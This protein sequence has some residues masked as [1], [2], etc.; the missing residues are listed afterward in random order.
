MTLSSCAQAFNWGGFEDGS[1]FLGGLYANTSMGV[2]DF[3]MLV[4]RAQL[5]GF[6]AVRLPFRCKILPL[7]ALGMHVSND[8]VI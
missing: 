8:E 7:Y 2:G 6:N 4:Y 3:A 1:T 5:L